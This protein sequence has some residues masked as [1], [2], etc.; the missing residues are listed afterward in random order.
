MRL[1]RIKSHYRRWDLLPGKCGRLAATTSAW[2]ASFSEQ[3]GAV[4]GPACL[5]NPRARLYWSCPAQ[6]RLPCGLRPVQGRPAAAQRVPPPPASLGRALPPPPPRQCAPGPS[7][8]PSASL[9]GLTLAGGSA[10]GG[11]VC[12]TPP[13]GLRFRKALRGT[14]QRQRSQWRSAPPALRLL[15]PSLQPV[16]PPR[17]QPGKPARRAPGLPRQA[18]ERCPRRGGGVGRE[19]EEKWDSGG[20][21]GAG[22]G[23]MRRAELAFAFLCVRPPSLSS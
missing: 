9:A 10:G 21:R 4:S 13:L 6:L 2:R 18:Q 22:Q 16:R 23:G 17:S 7:P 12:P 20:R 3:D 14:C 11:G 1:L 15:P 5:W 19:K 8:R